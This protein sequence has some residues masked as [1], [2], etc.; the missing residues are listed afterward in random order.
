MGELLLLNCIC[1]MDPIVFSTF[2]RMAQI[3]AE[4]PGLDLESPDCKPPDA[5]ELSSVLQEA[6]RDI[7]SEGS[8]YCSPQCRELWEPLL[9][10]LYDGAKVMISPSLLWKHLPVP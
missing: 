7:L 8:L 4:C 3:E 5:E 6:V 10:G 1:S 2:A 9:N